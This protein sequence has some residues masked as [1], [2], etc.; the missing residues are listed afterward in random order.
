[1]KIKHVNYGFPCINTNHVKWWRKCN[2]NN[3]DLHF[4]P[5]KIQ[6]STSKYKVEY[7]KNIYR[8]W[9]INK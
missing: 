7:L 5:I 3:S 1:M 2:K 8:N 4:V 6:K 9:Q